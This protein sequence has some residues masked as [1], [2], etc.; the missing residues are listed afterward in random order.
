MAETRG[1]RC[2][3][4]AAFT[5]Y[6]SIEPVAFFTTMTAALVMIFYPSYTM[7]KMRWAYRERLERMNETDQAVF[8]QQV[9]TQWNIYGN[10]IGK[11]TVIVMTLFLGWFFRHRLSGDEYTYGW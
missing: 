10:L 2:R 5:N 11:P 6:L 3:C 9:Q 7:D 1:G 8:L 4:W